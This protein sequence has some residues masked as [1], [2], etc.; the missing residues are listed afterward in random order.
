MIKME[1]VKDQHL[2][3]KAISIF[4]Y[5]PR[6]DLSVQAGICLLEENSSKWENFPGP[7]KDVV[8][9]VSPRRAFIVW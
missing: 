5:V 7:K 6:A 4:L 2:P 3:R 8:A 9:N 1:L